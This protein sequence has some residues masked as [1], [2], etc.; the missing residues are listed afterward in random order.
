MRQRRK[1]IKEEAKALLVEHVLS[2]PYF[3]HDI[4]INVSGIKE[5][6]NQPHKHYAE[7]NEALLRLPE[8]LADSEYLDSVADPKGRDYSDN[9]QI[10]GE[11]FSF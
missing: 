4:R 9:F 3:P 6:L 11:L 8:L 1:E 10:L 5:W 2:H 7:K